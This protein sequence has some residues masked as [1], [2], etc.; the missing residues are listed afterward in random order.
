MK[1]AGCMVIVK[2]RYPSPAAA[3][4]VTTP[5]KVNGCSKFNGKN[6]DFQRKN[7]A[8]GRFEHAEIRGLLIIVLFC[9]SCEIGEYCPFTDQV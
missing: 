4:K 8:P 5:F 2:Q 1:K 3:S 7:K 6:R 9:H